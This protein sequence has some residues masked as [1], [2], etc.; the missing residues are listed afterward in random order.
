MQLI[1]EY[2]EAK[3]INEIGNVLQRYAQ[4]LSALP[5]QAKQRRLHEYRDL[6]RYLTGERALAWTSRKWI[7]NSE[8]ESLHS[9]CLWHMPEMSTPAK[10]LR[11]INAFGRVL[12]YLT[13]TGNS[14]LTE[15][16]IHIILDSLQVT[17]GILVD[18]S[19]LQSSSYNIPA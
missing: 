16:E 11:D 19:F 13:V 9:C 5:Y 17:Y 10:T 14:L 7:V 6:R 4:E 18:Y 8:Q 12:S 15:D 2:L 3:N 1:Q